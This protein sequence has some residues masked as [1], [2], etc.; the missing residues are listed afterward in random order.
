LQVL[1]QPK[2]ACPDNSQVMKKLGFLPI[3][4]IELLVEQKPYQQAIKRGMDIVLSLIAI[5]CLSPI[6]LLL[7][8]LIKLDSKGSVLYT[9]ERIGY[10]E[11]R[12]NMY[13][14][15]SM[16]VDAEAQFEKVKALNETN[17]IMFKSKDDPRITR[18]GKF[19]R[20]SSLD[21]LPQ[22]FNILK[23]DMSLVGPRP[24]LPRELLHYEKWHRVKFLRPQGLTGLW[25]ISGRS[26]ITDFDDV[27][28]L[29]YQ[30][31]K[32]WN[33]LFDLKIILKTVPVVLFGK[34]AD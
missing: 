19:L 8:I 34:G 30:Y 11:K 4:N 9:Q 23:G 2:N 21:E 5:I 29:D 15:R 10:K 26:Q 31:N 7:A 32:N 12:F 27:I 14:F 24:P 16:V 17:H 3:E 33:I 6:L 18:V 13:K 20:K 28:H 25:Q 22:L 1:Q